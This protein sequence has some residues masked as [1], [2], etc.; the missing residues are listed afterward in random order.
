MNDAW[1][2]AVKKIEASANGN[3]T[4][5]YFS[6]RHTEIDELPAELLALTE[7]ETLECP[8]GLSVLP[9]WLGQLK[10]L[11]AL[12]FWDSTLPE[13]LVDLP[14]LTTV[15][16][17]QSPA[18]TL[19]EWI[20]GLSLLTHLV[21]VDGHLE[22]LPESIGELGRLRSL[23]LSGNSLTSLPE[24]LRKLTGLKNLDLLQ[25][26]FERWPEPIEG[27]T[28]LERLSIALLEAPEAQ[29]MP[30]TRA[31]VHF[32]PEPEYDDESFPDTSGD[33]NFL[34][35][36]SVDGQMLVNLLSRLSPLEQLADLYLTVAQ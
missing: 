33:L 27:L 14:A 13:R 12:D 22:S 31:T 19:P 8:Q 2:A 30:R 23:V 32:S 24:G 4:T 7:L 16:V 10:N 34:A 17:R 9:E 20:G 35:Q 11:H 26:G 25:N 6:L 29:V 15:R 3:G 36:R 28:G 1:D 18:R 21:L 5:R